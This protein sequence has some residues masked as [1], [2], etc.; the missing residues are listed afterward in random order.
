LPMAAVTALQALRDKANIQKGQKVLIVGSSGGVGT[1]PFSWQNILK[2]EV[3]GVCSSKNVQ[4]TLSLGADHVLDYT[5]E[6][7]SKVENK[8][9]IILGC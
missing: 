3:T 5:K 8:F 9:N 4:Q 2:A 7:L 1:L 6:Y